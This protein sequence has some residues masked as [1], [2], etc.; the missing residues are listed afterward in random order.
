MAQKT[1]FSIM[2]AILLIFSGLAYCLGEDPI[3][4]AESESGNYTD[5][6]APTGFDRESC[7]RDCQERYGVGPYRGG[8]NHQRNDYYLYARCIEDCNSRFWKEY[9]RHMRDLEKEKP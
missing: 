8:T 5:R 9:D 1:L 2:A 6:V 7:E 4:R 3:V